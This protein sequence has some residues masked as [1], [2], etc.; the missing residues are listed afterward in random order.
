[1]KEYL[2][3][4]NSNVPWLRKKK[5]IYVKIF[6][7]WEVQ[8][9]ERL[10]NFL[11]PFKWAQNDEQLGCA[12]TLRFQSGDTLTKLLYLHYKSWRPVRNFLLYL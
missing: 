2:Q 3:A 8:L 6:R 4:K 7:L 5:H 1:M 9:R 12:E 11:H 10:E